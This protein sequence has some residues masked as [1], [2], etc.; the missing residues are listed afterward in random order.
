MSGK[1]PKKGGIL[2]SLRRS[3]LVGSDLKLTRPSIPARQ[4]DL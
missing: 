3:P 1:A 2:D 4:V